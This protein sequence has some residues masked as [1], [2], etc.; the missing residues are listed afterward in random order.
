VK[1]AAMVAQKGLA[2][3]LVLS[4]VHAVWRWPAPSLVQSSEEMETHV[5]VAVG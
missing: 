5:A 3:S 2:V 4:L 1:L